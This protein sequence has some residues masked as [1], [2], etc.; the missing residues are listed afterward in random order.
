MHKTCSSTFLRLWETNCWRGTILVTEGEKL[1][2]QDRQLRS[3]GQPWMVVCNRRLSY[4]RTDRTQQ[5]R[6]VEMSFF[7][8]FRKSEKYIG[9]KKKRFQRGAATS[10]GFLGPTGSH[11]SWLPRM[12][13]LGRGSSLTARTSSTSCSPKSPV[14]RGMGYVSE[15]DKHCRSTP[16]VKPNLGLCLFDMVTDLQTTDDGGRPNLCLT[17][18]GLIS[19]K[20]IMLISN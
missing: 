6:G 1:R 15:G 5:T 20:I 10:H 9:S 17:I 18:L 11:A 7:L 16:W 8:R 2:T 13:A 14:R 19:H 4:S 3:N 12:T